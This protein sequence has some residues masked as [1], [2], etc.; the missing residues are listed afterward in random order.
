MNLK[1]PRR[2]VLLHFWLMKWSGCQKFHCHFR[3]SY[4]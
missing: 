3:T 4:W 2:L 1:Q